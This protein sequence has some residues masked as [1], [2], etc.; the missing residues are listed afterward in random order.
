MPDLFVA[1]DTSG[2]S[3]YYRNLV[4]RGIINAFALEYYDRNR[5]KLNSQYRDFDYFDEKFDF[6]PDDIK[7]FT[8]KGEKEGIKYDE[9]QFNISRD[10]IINVM[11]ALV[12]SNIWQTNEY[13]RI[14]NKGDTVI[15][16]ALEALS[17]QAGYRKI[18]GY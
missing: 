8:D 4:R 3:V 9:A 15:Q 10:Q 7:A 12:A 11:K 1:A 5:E 18:L 13:Y 16:K 14:L 2:Y 6:T 17:A